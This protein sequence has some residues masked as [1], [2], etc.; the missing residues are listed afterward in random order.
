VRRLSIARSLLPD[1]RRRRYDGISLIDV[2]TE[3]SKKRFIGDVVVETSIQ[4][5]SPR[6]LVSFE[7][8]SGRTFSVRKQN[9]WAG[10]SRARETRFDRTE[11]LRQ[12]GIIGTYLH[13][14]LL[15][16]NPHL[17]TT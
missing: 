11:G 5:L 3:A 1:G 2:K 8:H 14:S 4:G 16:K 15:P 9:R 17:P 7:N 6:T 12:G 10:S 13:G